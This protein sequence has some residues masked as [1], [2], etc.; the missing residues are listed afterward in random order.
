M[1]VNVARRPR[2]RTTPPSIP[3]EPEPTIA[4]AATFAIGE[5]NQTVFDCPSCSRP[6]ALGARRCPGCQ[7][8]LINGV[9]IAKASMFAAVGLAVGLLSG[10][11]AGLAYGLGHPSTSGPAPIVAITS[12]SAVAGDP[13][14][15]PT[16]VASATPPASPSD[17]PNS[18]IPPLARSAMDQALA[19]NGRLA[20]AADLLRGELA[21]RALDASAVAQVLRVASADSVFADDVADRLTSWSGSAAVANHLKTFYLSVHETAAAG[22]D[23]SVRN[24]A[25]YSAS[26]R[27][28]VRLL[29]GMPALDAELRASAASAGVTLSDAVAP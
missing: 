24:T 14:P 21:A 27:A 23:A 19:V 22:L 3:L 17:D 26:A 5:I 25:A 15:S 29:A 11:A 16:A 28:L 12:P 6:L 9:Q 4:P 7:T 8:R 13:T 2:R 18:G 1:T 10:G 20:S